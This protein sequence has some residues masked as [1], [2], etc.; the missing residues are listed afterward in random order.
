MLNVEYDVYAFLVVEVKTD[1]QSGKVTLTQIGL[2]KK[3]LKI[4]GMLD[5]NSTTTPEATI[6]L[7]TDSDVTPFNEPR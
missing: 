4:V 2:T 5:S 7:G 6:P 1:K 3:V